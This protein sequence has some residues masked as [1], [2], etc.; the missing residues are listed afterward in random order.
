MLYKDGAHLEKRVTEPL[1]TVVPG[2]SCDSCTL[3][4]KLMG[5]PALAKPRNVWCEHCVQ[6][7]GCAIYDARPDDCRVYDCAWLLSPELGPEWKPERARFVLEVDPGENR[8]FVNVDPGRPDAWRKEPY[9]GTLR[10]WA[11][12][13]VRTRRQILIRNGARI[14]ALLPDGQTDLGAVSEDDVIVLESKGAAP[15]S[16]FRFFTLHKDDPRLAELRRK[17]A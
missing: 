16:R 13:M 12:D 11:R 15:F 17:P 5:V 1:S 3:C 2:R 10:G 8:V 14:T 4:C 7:S 6:G 9:L